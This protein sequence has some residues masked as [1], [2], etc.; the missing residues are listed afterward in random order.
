MFGYFQEELGIEVYHQPVQRT[1]AGKRFLIGHGDGLGPGDTKYKLMKK[2]FTSRLCQWLFSLLHPNIAIGVASFFSQRSRYANEKNT[3]EH[4]F[5]GEDRE[6]LVLYAKRKLTQQPEIDYF[7]FGHRHVPVSLPLG[8]Q[9][10]FINLGDWIKHYSYAIFDGKTLE[11][12]YFQ[13][14]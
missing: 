13:D 12:Q 11:I 14:A 6:W 1:I 8:E 7:I 4:T 10:T 9:A 2:V 3:E 5:L